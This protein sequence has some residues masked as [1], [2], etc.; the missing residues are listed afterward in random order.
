[1]PVCQTIQAIAAD[2]FSKAVDQWNEAPFFKSGAKAEVTATRPGM[3]LL[4]YDSFPKKLYNSLCLV[5][6]FIVAMADALARSTS[7][8]RS[9]LRNPETC[10]LKLQM[11]T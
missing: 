11:R 5:G 10:Q 1:M 2:F 6:D 3:N 4:I 8:P 7:I 9:A